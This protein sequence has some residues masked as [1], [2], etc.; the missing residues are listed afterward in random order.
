MRISRDW[1]AA[2]QDTPTTT[3]TARNK[4]MMAEGQWIAGSVV[5]LTE[6]NLVVSCDTAIPMAGRRPRRL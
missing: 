1:G 3:T 5:A 4:P 2:S 6:R